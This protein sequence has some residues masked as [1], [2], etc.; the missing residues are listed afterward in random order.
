VG[1]EKENWLGGGAHTFYKAFRGKSAFC[2]KPSITYKLFIQKLIQDI[3]VT[4][5]NLTK[6]SNHAKK[7]FEHRNED[8]KGEKDPFP[9]EDVAGE[10]PQTA[11]PHIHCQ[12]LSMALCN[13]PP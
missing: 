13:W 10:D 4:I 8:L 6:E 7:V 2:G 11:A 9:V 3:L 5:T 12:E 1:I